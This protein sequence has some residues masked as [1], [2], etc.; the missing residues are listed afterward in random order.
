MFGKNT[1]MNPLESRKQLLLA[2]SELNRAQLVEDVA[3]LTADVRALADHAKSI[4][5]VASTA[6][7]LV[8]GLAAL[9]SRKSAPAGEKPSWLHTVLKGAG[10]VSS[11]WM[12][13]RP[14]ERSQIDKQK[15]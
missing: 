1:P 8:A 6:A 15:A 9:R 10:L 12:A 5:W 2:E 14:R 4:G 11:L 3:A 13:F 7:A